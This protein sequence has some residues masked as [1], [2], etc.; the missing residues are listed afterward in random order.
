MKCVK[1]PRF[2]EEVTEAVILHYGSQIRA[3]V[4]PETVDFQPTTAA[5]VPATAKPFL[6][7]TNQVPSQTLAARSMD[8]HIASQR[9]A[10]TSSSE[11]PTTH[12]TVKTLV[13][14]S[15]VTANSTPSSSPIIYTLVTTIV[16]PNNSNTAAPVT[17][18]TIGPSADPGS[19]PTT[20]TP[21][22]HTRTNPSTLSH[23]TRKTTHFGNQTTLPATLSTSTHN[24]TSSHKSAQSTHAPGPTTAAHNT[25]QTASPATPASGPTLAPRP[26][27]PKTGIYQVLNGSRLCI[28]AEMGIELMV[29]DTGSVFSPQR[30]F[31]IDPN[32]TQTSGNCGSQK[33]NLLLNFQGGFVN[34]TFFKDENSYYINE[35]GAYLTVSNPEKIY[36]GMKSSVVMFETGVGH[37]FKCV[38]E[39]SIQLSTHFQLKTMNVQFQAFD[40]EDDHF[41]NGNV[42]GSLGCDPVYQRGLAFGEMPCLSISSRPCNRFL[43]QEST[44]PVSNSCF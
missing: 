34:L 9:A 8:G 26:S 41:G 43:Q 39:Q 22:A 35:V 19:L 12:T 10:T 16:T 40:F 24:S 4:F 29:Q 3:K 42:E 38:S 15:L 28:K 31:N 27:S 23:K 44:I 21:L 11:P 18:A 25:T 7:L 33:S 37:S 5:T 17:E 32:A 2:P 13:T 20:S 1:G 36:Q 30:Y 6:H 14:T